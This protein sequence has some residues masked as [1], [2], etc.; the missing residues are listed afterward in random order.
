MESYN[1]NKSQYPELNI[2]SQEYE[3]TIKNKLKSLNEEIK[4]LKNN[5]FIHR[6]FTLLNMNNEEL[7]ESGVQNIK[8][9]IEE[10]NLWKITY[11]HFTKEY[12][13]ANYNNPNE[14]SDEDRKITEEIMSNKDIHSKVSDVSFGIMDYNM[15]RVK[16]Y[17]SI[18]GP[19]R[20]N[21]YRKSNN[22]LAIINKDFD[23][24]LD[25]ED[26]IE[27]ISR[28]SYNKHIPEFLALRVF[29]YMR[30]NEWDDDDIIT[31]FTAI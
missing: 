5:L 7:I 23:L 24:E 16:Y 14:D 20:F 22:N 1:D 26:Q 9:I 25:I 8:L 4:Y 28:Y 6:L 18:N 12:N 17:I 19:S 11:T 29:L 3:I 2:S 21:I 13:E 31:Y 30:N 27:L 15:N 10:D